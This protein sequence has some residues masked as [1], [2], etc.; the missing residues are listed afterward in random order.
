M[1]DVETFRSL[2]P[3]DVVEGPPLM[4]NLCNEPVLF[5]LVERS[6]DIGRFQ[7]SYFEIP[8]AGKVCSV[9]GKGGV[10]WA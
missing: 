7:L 2:N 8:L 10:Q 6:G 9:D 5:T 4:P 3:G 1:L